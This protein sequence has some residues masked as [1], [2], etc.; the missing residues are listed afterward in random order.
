MEKR[1]R[2]GKFAKERINKHM[3]FIES[4]TKINDSVN[5]FVWVTLG[6]VLLIGTG[7]LM[8]VLTRFF[9][10]SHLKHWMKNTIGSI[11]RKDVSGHTEKH[12]KSISQFQALCTALAAT[13]GVGNIAGVAAAIVSGG[14]GAIF[15]MWVAAFF[16][17]MT[18]YSEN[19]LG[20]FYR[21][22]NSRGEWAGGAMYYLRD[23]L[24]SKKGC[25]H[26]GKIL[27]VL[28]SIFAVLASFGIGNMGQVNKIVANFESAFQ[29]SSLSNVIVYSTDGGSVSLYSVI[30]GA[31]IMIVAGCIILGGLKRIAAFAEK[32]VP[33]MVICF[34]LGS[35]VVIIAHVNNIG[36]AFKAIFETAFSPKAAWEALWA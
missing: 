10:V 17:M 22:K 5:T 6:L 28:F 8:T 29:I 4:L 32:I 15:W 1:T 23:G 9:Q 30:I 24:G 33:F 11:F 18:N 16:G 3:S 20:I 35:L 12:E 2:T 26:I 36:A 27:A 19:V 13:V 34:L 25:K 31:V 14:A 7:V 21:R